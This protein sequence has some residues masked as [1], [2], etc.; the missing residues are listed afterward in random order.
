MRASLR[1][2]WR[3]SFVVIE[4]ENFVICLFFFFFKEGLNGDKC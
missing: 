3:D 1:N 2:D 4:I